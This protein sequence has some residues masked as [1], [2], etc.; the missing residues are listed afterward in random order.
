MEYVGIGKKT[1]RRRK[2]FGEGHLV[3][4][5]WW[6]ECG[7]GLFSSWRLAFKDIVRD[8]WQ[9][10]WS[11]SRYSS[12]RGAECRGVATHRAA[13]LVGWLRERMD[14]VCGYH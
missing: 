6:V 9:P 3:V 8:G 11:V 13:Q 1:E 7:G 5:R 4:E 14:G 2:C 12:G 10:G